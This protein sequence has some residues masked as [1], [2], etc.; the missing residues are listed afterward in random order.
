MPR[1]RAALVCITIFIFAT[2][3]SAQDVISLAGTWHFQ[4]D[5]PPTADTPAHRRR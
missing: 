3:A 2:R 5:G 1:L 4:L